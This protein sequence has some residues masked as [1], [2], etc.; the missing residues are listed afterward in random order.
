MLIKFKVGNYLSFKEDVEFSLTANA[1]KEYSETNV[2]E[3]DFHDIR[4]L[5]AGVIYGANSAGKSNLIKGLEFMKNFVLNSAKE[6]QANEK[7]P[8][9]NFKLN[10][11]SAKRPSAFEIEFIQDNKWYLYG[12]HVDK[13]KVSK[14]Y[15]YEVRRGKNTM[16][17]QRAYNEFMLGDKFEEGEG[18]EKK[19]RQ[20]AL[21]ISVIAQFNGAIATRIVRWF[22]TLIFLS[23]INFALS[24][25]HSINILSDEKRKPQLLK[26]LKVANLGFDDIVIRRFSITEEQLLNVPEEIRKLVLSASSNSPEQVLTVHKRYDQN[27]KPAG[28]VEFTFSKEESLGTQKYFALAGHILDALTQGGIVFIDELDARL[29]PLL[30]KLIA[31]FFNSVK[32]NPTKAQLVFSTHNT[33]LLSDKILRRDQVYIIDKDSFGSSKIENLMDK[34]VRNDASFEKDYI[35]GEYDGVPFSGNESPKLN[36]FDDKDNLTL[37]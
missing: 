20:N 8:V 3:P 2:F 13:E 24:T 36:L 14:E 12:F 1:T 11:V 27:D 22:Q 17:F 26:I 5:K 25:N 10:T 29:H 15:L 7:I 33:N 34:G 6:F 30:S 35:S 19:T 28:N 32:D 23:D 9:E 21:F 16:F 37:F 31:Q 4:L 18:L